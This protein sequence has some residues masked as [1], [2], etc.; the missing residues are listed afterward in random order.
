MRDAGT[1]TLQACLNRIRRGDVAA[2]SDLI[3]LSQERLRLL[4][5]RAL[6]RNPRVRRWETF[7]DVMQEAQIRL[8]QALATVSLDSV[9][10]FLR[11]AAWHIR[12]VLIEAARKHYGPRG[13]GMNHAT[14]EV[15]PQAAPLGEPTAVLEDPS[16][17][18]AWA[19]LHE[20]VQRMPEELRTVFDLVWYHGVEHLVAAELLGVSVST[21]QR[22]WTQA[23]LWLRKCFR[24]ELPV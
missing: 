18:A 15:G 24:G 19:E 7:E 3:A 1:T 5:R 8:C 20:H 17:L 12:N 21:V 22:R 10:D 6:R 13:I 9:L 4:S 2:R 23:R 14:P 16:N 11:L